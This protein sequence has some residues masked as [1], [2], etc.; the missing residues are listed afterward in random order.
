MR[1]RGDPVLGWAIS[2]AA[3]MAPGAHGSPTGAGAT[4]RWGGSIRPAGGGVDLGPVICLVNDI[5]DNDTANYPDTIDPGPNQVFFYL[6][7]PVVGGVPGTYTTSTD[8]KIGTPSSGGC[9]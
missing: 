4:P 6:V 9:P 2:I 5:A 3:P 7:R 1:G 8:G